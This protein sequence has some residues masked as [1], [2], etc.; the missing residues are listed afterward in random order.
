M[1]KLLPAEGDLRIYHV[2][3][4]CYSVKVM[5]RLLPVLLVLLCCSSWWLDEAAWPEAPPQSVS[6]APQP[7]SDGNIGCRSCHPTVKLDSPHQIACTRC[8]GGN[9]A[10]GTQAKAHH[11]L[12]A[13]PGHPEQVAAAC[14][15]CHRQV[16]AS[17]LHGSHFTLANK[18]N[19]VRHHFGARDSLAGMQE[20]PTT[21][22]SSSLLSL[23]DDML[24]RRCLRCHVSAPGDQ[25]SAVT[26]G[27]GCGACHLS[28]KEGKMESHQFRAPQDRQCLSCHYG[29]YVGWDYYGRYEHDYNW[30]YRTPYTEQTPQRYPSRP[31]GIE[32]HEL[33]PDIHQQRGLVCI[34][35]HE[36]AGHDRAS[37]PLTCRSCHG[38][39]PGQMLPLKRLQV[40]DNQLQLI[41]AVDDRQH[42]VPLLR[43]PA[44]QQYGH[45]VDCQ[46]CHAQW[47]FNDSSTH[48]LRTEK[49][50]YGQWERLM[51]QGSSEIETLL[52]HNVYSSDE[53]PLTMRDGISGQPRPGIWLQGFGQR[54]WEQMIVDRDTDG[55]IKVFRPILDLHLSMVDQQGKVIFDNQSGQGRTRLP[56]VPH[57]TG[58]AGLFYHNRF[59]HLLG[60]AKEPTP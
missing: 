48:L 35:C 25:Y 13:H 49:V 26:R 18:I 39:Q 32:Y 58:P 1:K 37:Q 41:G 16:V 54:R 31:Y 19:T 12:I 59:Q 33:V 23:A 14:G 42:P 9:G 28:W 36:R 21:E 20:I 53:L 34:D 6:S 15:Q 2:A 56:Y 50:D 52:Q 5:N 22:A 51:V 30:E 17:A 38:W 43:H 10:E 3:T 57:T 24:R 7:G 44:H 45:T 40:R 4:L 47:G 27:V 46:V 29:N 55:I 8:H 11:G 60:P